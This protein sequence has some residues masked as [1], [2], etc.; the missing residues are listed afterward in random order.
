VTPESVITR[1]TTPGAAQRASLAL[2]GVPLAATLLLGMALLAAARAPLWLLLAGPLLLGVPH[3]ASDLRSLV[4]RPGLHRRSPLL[5][6]A[7]VPLLFCCVRPTLW[8]GLLAA[9]GALVAA[10]AS[11]A[12]RALLG[13]ACALLLGAALW[14]GRSGDLLFA[15]LHNLVALVFAAALWPGGRKALLW[16]AGAVVAGTLVLLLTPLPLLLPA[17]LFDPGAALGGLQLATLRAGLAPA[18]SAETG[19]RLVLL[20]GF[21]QAAHYAAWLVLIPAAAASA[22]DGGQAP[23]LASGAG[24]RGLWRGAAQD[25]GA[26][27]VWLCALLAAGLAGWA[28]LDAAAAREGYLRF[29]GFHGHLELAALALWAAE[30]RGWAKG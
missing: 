22:G 24:A 21:L 12:R 1:G 16:P 3:V 4:L 15:H 5:L 28:L 20:Y 14:A 9:G 7:G 25:L 13:A 29:A 17:H 27:L 26:P 23:D 8:A 11:L 2:S 10:R 30:G 19:T 6:A 18:F